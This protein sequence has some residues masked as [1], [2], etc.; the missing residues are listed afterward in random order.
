MCI[1]KSGDVRFPEE[2][3]LQCAAISINEPDFS[4]QFDHQKKVWIASWKCNKNQKYLDKAFNKQSIPRQ[5][6]EQI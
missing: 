5:G 4:V 2:D 3:I 6:Y 1:T